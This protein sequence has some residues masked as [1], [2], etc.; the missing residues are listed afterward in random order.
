MNDISVVLTCLLAYGLAYAGMASFSLGMEKHYVQARV[1]DLTASRKKLFKATGWSFLILAVLPAIYGWGLTIGIVFW[2]GFVSLAA[3]S[4]VLVLSYF[5]KRLI[6][7][8]GG[9]A[10]IAL[11]VLLLAM[12]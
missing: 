4:V 2:T 5:P 12:L 9:V 10:G 3:I 11:S 6:W 8:G 1:S 7:L